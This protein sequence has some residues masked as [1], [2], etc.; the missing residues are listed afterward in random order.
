M[1]VRDVVII[2]SG[3]AGL[4]TAI[5][6][7]KAGLTYTVLEKG[8][9]V[10]TVFRYPTN[11]VFFTTAEL[12]EI[13]TLP[14]VTPYD[15]PTRIEALRYYRRVVDY[16]QLEIQ[17][18]EEVL[19]VFPDRGPDDARV[20]SLESRTARGVRRTHHARFVV[21]A[22]GAFDHPNLLGVAGEDLPHV[23]HYYSETHPYYRQRVVIVGG[24]NSAAE[25]AL[26]LYRSGSTVTLVHRGPGLGESIKYWVLPDIENRIREGSIAARF[27]T[28][29]LEIR[30]TT[31]LVECDGAREELDADAVLLLTGHHSDAGLFDRCGIQYD[32]TCLVPVFDPHTFETNVEGLF[33]VGQAQTGRNAGRIF[34]ENGRFHGEQAI[35]V[36]AERVNRP[37]VV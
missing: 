12:L 5:A 20:L 30:P 7:K 34:I 10:N 31:V 15:K 4:A 19:R 35:R 2:G 9:V 18:G 8:L 33:I 16:Y 1:L 3:P 37:L 32:E 11:M 27:N 14:F 24:K 13:G 29:V 22:T 36:I 26:E 6:A 28:S 23:A 17:T 21:L 25:T